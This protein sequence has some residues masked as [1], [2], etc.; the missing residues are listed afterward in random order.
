[1]DEQGVVL[2]ECVRGVCGASLAKGE[3]HGR[4]C[5]KEIVDSVT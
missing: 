5:R 3:E 4:F 2:F 1:M